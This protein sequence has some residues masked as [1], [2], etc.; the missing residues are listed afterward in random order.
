MRWWCRVE[1]LYCSR[2]QCLGWVYILVS[3]VCPLRG[4]ALLPATHLPAHLPA[5]A[6][7]R[8]SLSSCALSSAASDDTRSVS[9]VSLIRCMKTACCNIRKYVEIYSE[10]QGDV[11]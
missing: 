2:A 3:L 4:L 7:P 8:T 11:W 5:P 1:T 10:R 6:G 9:E